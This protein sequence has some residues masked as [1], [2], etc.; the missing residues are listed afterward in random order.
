M[1]R[2]LVMLT[3]FAVAAYRASYTLPLLE[4]VLLGAL[5]TLGGKALWDHLLYPGGPPDRF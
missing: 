2:L 3:V 4:A 5:V 1:I